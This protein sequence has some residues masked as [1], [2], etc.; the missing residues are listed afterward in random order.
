MSC[1]LNTNWPDGKFLKRLLARIMGYHDNQ[2]I[3]K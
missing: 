1:I 2:K 3:N